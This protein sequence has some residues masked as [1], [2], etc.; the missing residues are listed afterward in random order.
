MMQIFLI[1]L[2]SAF[3]KF[4]SLFHTQILMAQV[5]PFSQPGQRD[6]HQHWQGPH[7]SITQAE[8]QQVEQDLG[9]PKT[10]C[11]TSDNR[12]MN[13]G[14]KNT[15]K[16][17]Q[18]TCAPTKACSAP[19]SLWFSYTRGVAMG[20]Q[21]WFHQII[22]HTILSLTRVT[23]QRWMHMESS[24]AIRWCIQIYTTA[25]SDTTFEKPRNFLEAVN[26]HCF[27]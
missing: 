5:K 19:N 17:P 2:S 20:T 4:F 3:Q 21:S 18:L 6:L 15:Q 12:M 1:Q 10:A 7:T 26:P 9:R 23:Q 25:F 11:W 13:L 16:H 8:L 14:P 27:F 24:T 22:F